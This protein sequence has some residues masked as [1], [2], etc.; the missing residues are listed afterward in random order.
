[1]SRKNK[2]KFNLKN[3]YYAKVT[4]LTEEKM[5][6]ET[7]I[8]LPGSVSLSLDPNGENENFYADGGV[9]Y[10]ISNNQGYDGD[11]ELALIPE[12]FRIDILGETQDT[13]KVLVENANVEASSFAFLFEFDGDVRHIKHVLYNCTASRPGI[14]SQTN[15]E[16]KEVKTETL[17][18]KAAP[19]PSGLVKARTGDETT[20]SVYKDWYKAVYVPVIGE[21]AAGSAT[22]SGGK[23]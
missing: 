3:A 1:M 17:S 5:T 2:V 22:T 20:D 16:T 7:P 18:I 14:A 23:S 15:E 11:Y 10:V 8:P 6:F 4:E 19:T 9:Y 12:S 13:N 21:I